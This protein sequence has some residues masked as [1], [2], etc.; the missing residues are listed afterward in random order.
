MSGKGSPP[1]RSASCVQG[2]VVATRRTRWATRRPRIL[3]AA[4]VTAHPEVL[5]PLRNGACCGRR[6]F[7]RTPKAIQE[8][9]SWPGCEGPPESSGRGMPEERRRRPWEAPAA[10]GGRTPQQYGIQL[11]RHGRG[12]PDTEQCW[13]LRVVGETSDR[14]AEKYCHRERP[15][16]AGGESYH[17]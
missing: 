5:V 7:S 9:P 12:N 4:G 16:H 6:G 8:H 1:T 3:E 17:A 11:L 10:P 15:L 14:Q 13:N 2:G